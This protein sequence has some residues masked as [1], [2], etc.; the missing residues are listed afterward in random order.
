MFRLLSDIVINYYAILNVASDSTSSQIKAAYR[1]LAKK[2][3]PDKGGDPAL[4]HRIQEAYDILSN[5]LSRRE[6]DRKRRQQ[7]FEGER[8]R[9]VVPVVSKQTVDIFDDLVDVFSRRLGLESKAPY[10]VDIILT[11]AEAAYGANLELR[12]PV[13]RICDSCFGFGGTIL[14]TCGHC[15]GSGMVSGNERAFVKI[16]PGAKRGDCIIAQSRSIIIRGRIEIAG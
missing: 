5:S 14:S 3:H 7:P 12:I 2:H 11:N 8:Y 16:N 6:Y 4:F 9:T 1:K 15:S 13:K 10:D